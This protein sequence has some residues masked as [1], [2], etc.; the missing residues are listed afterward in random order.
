MFRLSL[1]IYFVTVCLISCVVSTNYTQTVCTDLSCSVDCVSTTFQD[2]D[3]ITLHGGSSIKA[4]CNPDDSLLLQ[5][6]FFTQD[7]TGGNVTVSTPTQQC[8]KT[9]TGESASVVCNTATMKTKTPMLG[10]TKVSANH[11]FVLFTKNT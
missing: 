8:I 3:C 10:N 2:T 5:M 6:I 1:I 4:H 9:V 7:C 11:T